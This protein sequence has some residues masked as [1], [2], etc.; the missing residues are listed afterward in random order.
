MVVEEFLSAARHSGRAV[1]LQEVECHVVDFRPR[2]SRQGLWS[3]FSSIPNLRA[4]FVLHESGC[5]GHLMPAVDSDGK[6]R[7][8]VRKVP[9]MALGEIEGHLEEVIPRWR[10]GAAA[11]SEATSGASASDLEEL[12]AAAWNLWMRE[13]GGLLDESWFSRLVD[14]GC[15]LRPGLFPRFGE[16]PS[17]VAGVE[18]RYRPMKVCAECEAMVS[19]AGVEYHWAV[20]GRCGVFKLVPSPM[21]RVVVDM[22]GAEVRSVVLELEPRLGFDAAVAMAI[23]RWIEM[24]TACDLAMAESLVG[25]DDT[26][27]GRDGPVTTRPFST[28]CDADGPTDSEVGRRASGPP[29]AAVFY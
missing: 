21:P 27:G 20:C 11:W 8:M 5:Y 26:P 7:H 22:D 19:P 14:Y 9:Q 6:P 17:E 12:Q 18:I 23:A 24:E 4:Q 1:E 29:R 28:D 3:R 13:Y 2:C 10:Q 16:L 25:G 15:G